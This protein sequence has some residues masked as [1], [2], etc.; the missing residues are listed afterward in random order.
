MKQEDAKD[1]I[2][3]MLKE[4]EDHE[5]HGH[6]T[7]IKRGAMPIN[8][9]TILSIWS[10]KRK[11][12]PDR[13]LNKHTKARICAHGGMQKWGVDYRETYSPV[14]NWIS[15]RALLTTSKIHNLPTKSIDFVLAFLQAELDTDVFMEILAGFSSDLRKTHV[16]KLN[17]SLYGLKQASSNWYKHLTTA[18]KRRQVSLSNNDKCIFF[19]EGLIVLVYVDDCIIIGKTNLDIKKFV[20]L[21]KSGEENF[22]FTEEGS[23]EQYLGVDIKKISSNSFEMRQPF[24]IDEILKVFGNDQSNPRKVPAQKDPFHNNEQGLP[25]KY[26]WNYRRFLKFSEMIKATQGK[27]QPKRILFITM[28]KVCPENILGIIGA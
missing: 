2:Q 21:L 5:S 19:K 3:A 27:C 18:L 7:M 10:F 25:R 11:R 22:D 13:R 23:L 26:S 1:F 28:N 17:K 9:K 15:V 12:H 14:V 24:L 4:I 8:A 6:W 20:D 16:L